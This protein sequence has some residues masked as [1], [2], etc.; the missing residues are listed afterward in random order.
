M[1]TPPSNA[2][3][4]IT[5]LAV[6]AGS[7]IVLPGCDFLEPKVSSPFT[8]QPVTEAGLIREV[9]AKEAAA[10]AEAAAAAEKAAADIRAAQASA[11]RA[12][13]DLA[14]R[15]ATT[16]AEL[17]AEA[18]RVEAET[19]QRIAAATAAAEAAAKALTDRL[20]VLDTQVQAALAE[21]DQKRQAAAGV[22]SIITNNP[23]VKTADGATGGA[24]LGLLGL[25]GGWMGRSVGSRKRHDASYDQG[26][27]EERARLEES[28]ARENAAWEEA[29][30][31]LMALYAPPPAVRPPTPPSPAT[32]EAAA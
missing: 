30:A 17:T 18:A 21:I 22:L 8:G 5:L 29:T 12:A 16:A 10:K 19:G 32:P 13:I 6:L 27:Q 2:R 9:Q 28:R 24:V 15:Q 14:Q 7:A 25:A 23:L 31:R 26:A 3:R 20:A 11:R 1:P 4:F